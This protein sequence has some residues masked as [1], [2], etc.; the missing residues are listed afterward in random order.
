MA[1]PLAGLTGGA[2]SF[3]VA[4]TGVQPLPPASFSPASLLLC[5]PGK[6]PHLSVLLC[7]LRGA[8][9]PVGAPARTAVWRGRAGS[10][11]QTL[12]PLPSIAGSPGFPEPTWPGSTMRR[13]AVRPTAFSGGSW[14]SLGN[15]RTGGD[16]GWTQGSV[17][18]L[19]LEVIWVPK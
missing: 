19:S 14:G 2:F 16:R 8:E 17:R 6:L 13:M 18:Q 10:G 9:I 7:A 1:L 3:C 12:S 11:Q 5:D 4:P 15:L